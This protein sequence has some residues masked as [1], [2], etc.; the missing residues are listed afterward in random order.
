M[1]TA[2]SV[3]STEEKDIVE[4]DWIIKI[5][6][7]SRDKNKEEKKRWFTIYNKL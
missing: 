7:S 2:C 1:F 4:K 6:G 3:C 5:N